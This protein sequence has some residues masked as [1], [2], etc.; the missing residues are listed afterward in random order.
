MGTIQ[1][2]KHIIADPE[3][4][5]G[6]PVFKGTRVMVWQVLEMMEEGKSVG[7]ILKAFPAITKDHVS[8]ALGYAVDITKG[9]NYVLVAG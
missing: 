3:V 7:D 8:A 4:C 9:K 2:N 5:H 1:L 6:K